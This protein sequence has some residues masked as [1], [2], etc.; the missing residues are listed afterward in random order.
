MLQIIIH[1]K[2]DVHVNT[3]IYKL[4]WIL[5]THFCVFFYTNCINIKIIVLKL[6]T[7]FTYNSKSINPNIDYM[8]AVGIREYF[9]MQSSFKQEAHGPHCSP[10][11]PV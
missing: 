3:T 10:E 8:I 2:K 4:Y 9:L 6:E 7:L 1:K 11:K 5:C